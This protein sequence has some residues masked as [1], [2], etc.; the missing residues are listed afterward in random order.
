MPINREMDK[1]DMIHT[2]TQL[3]LSHKKEQNKSDRERQIAYDITYMCN[4]KCD[5]KQKT[6]KRFQKQTDSFQRKNMGE[7]IN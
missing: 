3:L 1:E 5:T 2:H 6:N 4:L 7:G